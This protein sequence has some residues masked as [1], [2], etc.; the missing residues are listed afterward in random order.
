MIDNN[1][2]QKDINDVLELLTFKDFRWKKITTEN[3]YYNLPPASRCLITN[4]RFVELSYYDGRHLIN[5]TICS[6]CGVEKNFLYPTH[7]LVLP[8]LPSQYRKRTVNAVKILEILKRDNFK[9]KLCSKSPAIDDK[10]FLEI[11][12]IIPFRKG[13]NCR[14]ENLQTLCNIC[15]RKKT[16]EE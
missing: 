7:F 2:D 14:Q 5:K 1:S 12:H 3:L 6:S 9:C 13:G 15:H 16:N 10:I 8:D 11:D 4:G